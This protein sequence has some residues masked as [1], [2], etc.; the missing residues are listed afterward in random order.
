MLL[1][2]LFSSEKIKAESL[3]PGGVCGW[4][5]QEF[6]SGRLEFEV[7]VGHRVE[8]K[9]AVE[10]SSLESRREVCA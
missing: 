6:S 7:P 5:D 10:Y 1:R 2:T 9:D 3:R 4:G 8:V